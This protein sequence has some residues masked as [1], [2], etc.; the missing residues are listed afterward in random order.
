VRPL[1]VIVLVGLVSGC[2]P[3]P[4]PPEAC[5]AAELPS[6]SASVAHVGLNAY[7]LQEEATR[8]LRRGLSP[9]PVLEEVL[10]KA[11]RMGATLI[12][13]NGFNDDPSKAGDS[14][15][16]VAKLQYDETALQGFDL[17]L[18]RAHAHGVKLLLPLGNHWD[19]YGGAKQYVAW[20]GL[21][22]P[23]EGDPRF[24]R[25]DAV[26]SHFEQN[27][28][29]LLSR[30]NAFDGLVTGAHPAVF[31]F[32][33]L[34]EPR[35]E[36][37]G[38]DG[39]TLRA[40]ID[41]VGATVK[42]AAPMALLGTG[43]EGFERD[44]STTAADFWAHAA[45]DWL[46]SAHQSFRLDTASPSVDFGSAH[47]YPESWGFSA[48]SVEE[49]GQRWIAEHTATARSLGKPLLLGEFGLKNGGLLLEERRAHYAA[50]LTC[51]R[52]TGALTSLPWMFA[53]DARADSDGFTFR[54]LDGTDAGDARNQYVDLVEQAAP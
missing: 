52:T 17:V 9:C 41:R 11:A 37:Q 26:I 4:A 54:W 21:P 30:K 49:A 16:Q 13:T 48:P 45:P 24:Y 50:W 35:G 19:A 44:R 3:S 27:A 1:L 53:N 29:R 47:L 15:M 18:T 38:D 33:L 51:A 22:N 43:E 28:R 6:F 14:A 10:T 7:F 2:G 8:C 20:A 5:P 46:F 36:G 39:T 42:A 32:E 25:D 40:W 31:A 12:R 34:N 23:V